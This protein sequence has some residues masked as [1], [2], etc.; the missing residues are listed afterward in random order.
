MREKKK[1]IRIYIICF[2]LFY[3][4]FVE[5]EGNLEMEKSLWDDEF[6]NLEVEGNMC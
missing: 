6:Y 4:I 3:C 1:I 2:I 5:K